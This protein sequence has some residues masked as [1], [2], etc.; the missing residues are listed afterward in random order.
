MFSRTNE[1]VVVGVCFEGTDV[2]YTKSFTILQ[3]NYQIMMLVKIQIVTIR[4]SFLWPYLIK[5]S[6]NDIFLIAVVKLSGTYCS[7]IPSTAWEGDC[8]AKFQ[9]N[10]V[11]VG[12]YWV[13]TIPFRAIQ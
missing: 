7:S 12:Y 2:T 10:L 6:Y 9:S 3:G 1:V 13:E 8:H 4:L 11:I 5:E